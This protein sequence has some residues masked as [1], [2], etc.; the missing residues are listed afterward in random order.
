MRWLLQAITPQTNDED[1]R[2]QGFLVIVVSVALTLLTGILG[3]NSFLSNFS[4]SLKPTQVVLLISSLIYMSC[5][6][7]AQRGIVRPAAY[8]ST[9]V[10]CLGIIAT[11][12]T[13]PSVSTISFLG[14]P[15]LLASIVLSSAHIVPVLTC[16]LLVTL[17]SINRGNHAE[18]SGFF[19]AISFVIMISAL[20][21]LS[22]WSVERALR[23]ARNASHALEHANQ[24]LNESNS[25]L[26]NR[27]AQ[28]TIELQQREVKL[29]QTLVE[30]QQTFA[31][32]RTSQDTIRELSTPI[33]PV[34]ANVLVAPIVGTIDSER[35]SVFMGSLLSEAERTSA[36]YL[37]IDVTGIPVI[38]TH[39]ARML[40]QTT[41][42]IKLLGA[43]VILTGIRPEVAQTLVSLGI[44][45]SSI[46]TR[47]T[48]QSGIAEALNRQ[49]P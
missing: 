48:L 17:Y 6:V 44:D 41:H 32:L 22:A 34:A 39:V 11:L 45:L 33:L 18:T 23:S 30:L 38:D 28:R 14:I 16:G 49:Q 20:A 26:E 3:I 13:N 2:R 37:I 42:A 19:S 36:R 21:Y 46:I 9:W 43:Q 27:V 29:Q 4:G 24:A 35:T 15:I 10:P 8:L 12:L 5:A 31:D 47:G 7:L 40:L 25:E 1:L